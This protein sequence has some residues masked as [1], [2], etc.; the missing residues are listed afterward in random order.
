MCGIR[1]SAIHLCSRSVLILGTLQ[2]LSYHISYLCYSIGPLLWLCCNLRI[3][4]VCAQVC[5]HTSARNA[6]FSVGCRRLAASRCFGRVSLRRCSRGHPDLTVGQHDNSTGQFK[7][8]LAS[9]PILQLTSELNLVALPL[10]DALAPPIYAFCNAYDN[11]GQCSQ[12]LAVVA[13]LLERGCRTVFSRLARSADVSQID[14]GIRMPH[15]TCSPERL[16][17]VPQLGSLPTQSASTANYPSSLAVRYV[18]I[19]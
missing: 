16:A 12:L 15:C 10:Y 11:M 19:C 4:R 9:T 1:R 8:S 14:V 13:A 17:Y 6:G 7:Q 5:W 3:A 2:T 18:M